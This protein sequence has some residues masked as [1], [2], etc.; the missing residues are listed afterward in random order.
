MSE[1]NKKP[2]VL[3]PY[4]HENHKPILTRR[5]FFAQTA[6]AVAGTMMVP[7]TL[8]MISTAAMGQD[9]QLNCGSGGSESMGV[10]VFNLE[11]AGGWGVTRIVNPH[12]PAGRDDVMSTNAARTQG[13]TQAMIGANIAP[14]MGAALRTDT[15]FYVGLQAGLGP[16]ATAIMSRLRVA[17]VCVRNVDDT[18]TNDLFFG[19]YLFKSG[20][21][22]G[23]L[24]NLIGSDPTPQ[25]ARSEFPP[26]SFEATLQSARI[27][28]SADITG[29]VSVGALANA[30]QGRFLSDND[31][32]RVMQQVG[33]MSEAK[34][35]EF[36]SR[37]FSA[38]L[39][40]LVKC[41]YIKQRA[42]L[43]STSGGLD[44][45]LDNAITT[46]YGAGAAAA[47]GQVPSIVKALVDGLAVVGSVVL[48]GYDYHA[49]GAQNTN[50]RDQ[51]AGD[52][53]GRAIRVFALKQRPG[54]FTITTDGSVS[55]SNPSGPQDPNWTADSGERHMDLVFVY[56][57]M[58]PTEVIKPQLGAFN[59]TS[60]GVQID[61]NLI[62]NNQINATM[63]LAAN[64]LELQGRYD[65]L[66]AALGT[67]PP[68][69][70]RA[71]FDAGYRLFGP[72]P[73]RRS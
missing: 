65:R 54:I 17:G 10:P 44:P 61:F 66:E 48:G 70:N 11:L 37:E 38:Q 21:Y 35:A 15:S 2:L 52:A 25:G 62:T 27:R 26:G 4:E 14:N 24:V 49:T 41:G 72:M 34:L 45:T 40:A 18:N 22:K 7:S 23:S 69:G 55:A 30:N 1:D 39:D 20:V 50:L 36:K 43:D 5:D 19:G 68:W 31:I 51:E 60:G 9:G 13:M 46:A 12:G 63:A 47:G 58:G 56:D 28:S 67:T 64:I 73:S 29:L 33:T 53:L 57:P 71:A 42:L 59:P 3:V 32:K 6:G 16:D 8:S